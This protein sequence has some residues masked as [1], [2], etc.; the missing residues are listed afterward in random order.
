MNDDELFSRIIGVAKSDSEMRQCFQFEMSSTPPSLFNGHLMRK[1]SKFK[2]MGVCDKLETA[3][4]NPPENCMFVI[5]G[6]YLL[7]KVVWDKTNRR[8][9]HSWI[10]WDIIVDLSWISFWIS[11]GF[12]VDIREYSKFFLDFPKLTVDFYWIGLFC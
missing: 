7:H 5:D 10:F 1:S 12:F 2:I 9:N 8:C 6:G 4:F 3:L 11:H